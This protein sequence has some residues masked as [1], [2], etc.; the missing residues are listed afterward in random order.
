M[1]QRGAGYEAVT[2]ANFALPT[3]AP[4]LEQIGRELEQG[5]GIV[6][7]RGLPVQKYSS[8]ELETLF[9]GICRHLGVPVYQNSHGQILRQICDEGSE[10]GS[11]YGQLDSA[12]G[13]FLSS[14]ARTASTAELRF[15][16]DRTDVVGLLCVGRAS[17]GGVSK[18]ASTVAVH[19]Q[20]LARRPDLLELLYQDYYRSR[21]GEETGGERVVYALPIFAVRDGKFTS[22][23]SRT[24]IEAA[25][26]LPEVTKMS[27]AQWEAL[28]LLAEI[29]EEICLDMVL[30]P[31]D[32]Q[33]LNNHVIYHARTAFEND[34][35]RG[36]ER[37]LYRIWLCVPNNR[38]LPANHRVLWGETE[39]G[40]LRG[41]IRHL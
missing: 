7:L 27:D 23:Y 8:A 10:V 30:E 25:Q 5:C 37:R 31:G 2:K 26:L 16:T 18:V 20:I 19:N 33:L 36:M 15:H 29:A 41:G 40:L 9:M 3:L 28:D 32:I 12:H 6:R 11:R 24:Y 34:P 4:L 35:Q 22:H 39:T 17:S 14:R 1:V 38:S 21:L 13:V